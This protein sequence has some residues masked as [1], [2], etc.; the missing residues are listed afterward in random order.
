ME[1][2]TILIYGS[3]RTEKSTFIKNINGIE[4]EYNHQTTPKPFPVIYVTNYKPD[5]N[6]LSLFNLV[7]H[8]TEDSDVIFEKGFTLESLAQLADKCQK[9]Y[10]SERL[11]GNDHKE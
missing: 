9:D 2:Q 8:F 7:L 5:E 3:Q 10:E 11:S 6:Q 1:S 4:T